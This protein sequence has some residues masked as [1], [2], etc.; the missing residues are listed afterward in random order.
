MTEAPLFKSYCHGPMNCTMSK[1]SPAT[2]SI[3]FK[4]EEKFRPY[5]QKDVN[6]SYGQTSSTGYSHTRSVSL[7]P[8][9]CGYFAF[10]PIARNFR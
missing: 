9:E 4:L 10:V 8:G 7:G 5:L 1:E 6:I 3:D 2:V